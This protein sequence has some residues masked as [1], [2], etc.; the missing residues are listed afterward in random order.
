MNCKVNRLRNFENNRE[1]KSKPTS[2]YIKSSYM[3]V[4]D[5]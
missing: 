5:V 2:K 3:Y 1:I 4:L